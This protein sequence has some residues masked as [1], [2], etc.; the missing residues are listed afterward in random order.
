M[1][2]I[3]LCLFATAAIVACNES[4]TGTVSAEDAGNYVLRSM[5]DST[6][7]YLYAS[8]TTQQVFILSDTIFMGVDGRFTDHTH[9]R[10]VN[11]GVESLQDDATT[12][13]WSTKG[14]TVIFEG[15]DGSNITANFVGQQLVIVGDGRRAV[16]SR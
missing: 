10:F 2:K 7:P 11:N 13:K 12:G 8:T 16:Y 15:D 14:A 1:R 5:N 3:V 9:V 4:V 6:L